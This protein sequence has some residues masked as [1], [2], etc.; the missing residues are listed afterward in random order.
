MV[1]DLEGPSVDVRQMG[2]GPDLLLIHGYPLDGAM[3]SSVARRLSDRFRVLKPDLPGRTGN[4]VSA[5]GSL[6]AYADF[7]ASI[8]DRLESPV[9]LA[10]FSMGGYV[11]LELMRRRH[12]K[13]G[14]LALVDTRAVADDDAA[15]TNRDRSIS[16]LEAQGAAAIADAMLPRLL[17]PE[18]ASR[19]D[20]AERVRR[21]ILRQTKEGLE[22]DLKAMRDRPDSTTLLR[23]IAVPT[24]VIA[25][26]RDV[27]STVAESQAMAS[28]IPG[29]R[30]VAIPG[31]GHLT[32][33][34]SPAAVAKAL[35][36]FFSG[37]L[38]PKT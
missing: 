11:S 14:A 34:E 22:S 26:E 16:S 12:P 1:F 13:V 7:V 15:K 23:Y 37:A 21:I 5:S 29:A 30:F 4:S 31:A 36:D 32:P 10:G 8:L 17:S 2:E 35:G 33:M 6:A 28:A 19:G 25:G 27:I 18:A 24:L 9:G 3:W 20:L 38:A